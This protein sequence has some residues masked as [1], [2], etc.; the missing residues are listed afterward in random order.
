[1]DI[2]RVIALRKLTT[3]LAEHFVGLIREYLTNLAP[4]LQPRSLLGDLVRYEKCAVKNQDNAFQDLLKLYR[5][6]AQASAL[7]IQEDLKPPLDIFGTAPEIVPAS[8]A[9]LPEGSDR[10]IT[11]VTPLKW[12]LTY[13]DLTPQRL[14]ELVA[15]HA[16]SGGSE[17]QSCVLHYL[18]MHLLVSR[19]PG[20]APIM[21]ALR[22]PVSSEPASEFGGLPFVHL[23]APIR[24]IRP[25]DAIIVQSTQLSGSAAFEEIVDLDAVMALGDPMKEKL[26]AL[27][28]QH[29]TK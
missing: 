5:P 12:I 25:A 3:A 22:I 2:A 9:Y 13:R 24:T 20:F 10:P 14:R 6:L 11:I 26:I 19:R 21:E 1:M 28:E 15:S 18:A 7:N 29:P 8:Y 27:V 4:M 23:S 17:L 16:R